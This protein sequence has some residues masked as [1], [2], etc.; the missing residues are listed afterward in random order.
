MNKQSVL[1]NIRF[2][3]V[4]MGTS[5]MV[6]CGLDDPGS[7]FD[8]E[9]Q[10]ERETEAIDAYLEANDIEAEVDSLTLIRY[11]MV[12]EGGGEMPEDADSINIDYE[13]KLLANGQVFD[14]GEEITFKLSNLLHAWRY[15]MPKVR[16]GG[17]IMIYAQSYY[18][19]GNNAIGSIPANSTMIF[20]VTL[21]EII[22][23]T[24]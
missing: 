21:H 23:S 3:M 13:G 5:L 4:I 2:W 12:E 15:M 6:A 7:G 9:G 22:P 10:F 11:V 8:L 19:Y 18:C 20:E 14:S 16:E 24:Q 1:V 17:T